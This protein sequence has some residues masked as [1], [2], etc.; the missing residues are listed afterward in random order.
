MI[1]VLHEADLTGSEAADAYR[2]IADT[3]LACTQYLAAY[4][5]LDADVQAKDQ[6][7]WAVTYAMLPEDRFPPFTRPPRAW[8]N[9]DATTPR[10]SSSRSASSSTASRSESPG[11]KRPEPPD[12]LRRDDLTNRAE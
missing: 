6:Q 4:P 3:T 11:R 2:A 1:K 10:Y 12:H 9:P 7:A 5:L 8:P